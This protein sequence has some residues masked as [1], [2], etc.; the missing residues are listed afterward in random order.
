MILEYC[1]CIISE[2]L[3]NIVCYVKV[4]NVWIRIEEK[5][6]VFF[7]LVKDDGIG[8]NIDMK[9]NNGSYY[10]LLGI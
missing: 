4:I 3:L 9:I 10:G 1:L 5:E 6:N 7:V 8:F 2:C